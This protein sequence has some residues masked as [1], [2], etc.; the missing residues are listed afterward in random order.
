MGSLTIVDGYHWHDD[1]LYTNTTFYQHLE[2]QV[3]DML[4]NIFSMTTVAY[5]YAGASVNHFSEGSIK[6]QFTVTFSSGESDNGT[7]TSSN[8]TLSDLTSNFI[9]SQFLQAAS[10]SNYS[11][12]TNVTELV[13]DEQLFFSDVLKP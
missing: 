10:M 12:D 1:L 8:V 2:G 4:D 11:I 7:T 3:T 13:G 9:T 6:V 5:H